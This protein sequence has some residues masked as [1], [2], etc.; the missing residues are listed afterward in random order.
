MPPEGRGPPARLL[1]HV[2]PVRG[3]RQGLFANSDWQDTDAA[4]GSDL[5]MLTGVS[6]L[7]AALSCDAVRDG[8]HACARQR[9]FPPRRMPASAEDSIRPVA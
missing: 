4:D 9:A 3:A 2:M 6:L 7:V 8:R 5:R 1:A